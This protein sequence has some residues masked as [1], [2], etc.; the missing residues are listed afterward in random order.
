MGK[1]II[2]YCPFN[3]SVFF[4][5]APD[6]DAGFSKPKINIKKKLQLFVL[7]FQRCLAFL[8]CKT[9]LRRPLRTVY[10]KNKPFVCI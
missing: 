3:E 5:P 9:A 8:I 2:R 7:S 1:K 6:P 4:F 10:T